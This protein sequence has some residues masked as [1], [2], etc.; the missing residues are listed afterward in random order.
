[1]I[2]RA[3]NLGFEQLICALIQWRPQ[4]LQARWIRDKIPEK[5]AP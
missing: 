2:K 4:L 5:L 1:M 3:A